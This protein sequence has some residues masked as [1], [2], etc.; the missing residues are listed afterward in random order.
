[1]SASNALREVVVVNLPIRFPNDADVI[2]EDAARFRALSDEE[3]M[4]SLRDLIATGA[5]LLRIGGRE[6]AMRE[7]ADEETRKSHA[8]IR[9]F[10]ARHAG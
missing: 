5:F 2:A 1:M 8:A 7:L 9:E 4:R 3:R 10:I 6:A